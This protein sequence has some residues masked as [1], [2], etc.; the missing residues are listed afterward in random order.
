MLEG[1]AKYAHLI[2]IVFFDDLVKVLQ[3]LVMSGALLARENLHCVY[4]VFKVI[5]FGFFPFFIQQ[6]TKEH[7]GGLGAERIFSDRKR[8]HILKIDLF[9][10]RDPSF[11]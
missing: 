7:A 8:V 1:I 5:F 10:N 2:N 9:A 4:S 11:D 3:Q 6:L